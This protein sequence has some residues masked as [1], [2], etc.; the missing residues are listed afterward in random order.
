MSTAALTLFKFNLACISTLEMQIVNNN[1]CVDHLVDIT[2]LHEKH[3][4][5]VEQKLDHI[6]DKQATL[7]KVN[8]AQNDR[9]YET[10]IWYGR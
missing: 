8:K 9:L 1:K 3:F 7:I 5:A 6:A 2:N 10:K 4:K